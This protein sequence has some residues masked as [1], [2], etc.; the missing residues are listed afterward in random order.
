MGNPD[1]HKTQ[2][3]LNSI[4]FPQGTFKIKVYLKNQMH[5][6]EENESNFFIIDNT[7]PM[8]Q[9]FS[10][11]EGA[12]S[13]SFTSF[14]A[15]IVDPYLD[16]NSEGSGLNLDVAL[17][18]IWP[19]RLLTNQ[20]FNPNS[21]N[22]NT[23][24]FTITDG[25]AYARNHRGEI[26]T[27]G[28]ELEVWKVISG[29][30]QNDTVAVKVVENT[31]NGILKLQTVS[32]SNY[33]K[34]VDFVALFAIPSFT[35]NNG[36]DRVGAVP[37][38]P[39][40][41]DAQYVCRVLTLD[42]SGNK[43]AF[44]AP[45]SKLELAAGP[46]TLTTDRTFLFYGLVPPDLATFTSSS[47]T[48]RKGNIV[49]DAQAV[50]V[51]RSPESLTSFTLP[52]ANGLPGDGYQ[53][54]TGQNGATP[55]QGMFAF[56]V[57]VSGSSAG[58]LNTVCA[59]GLASGSSS[60]IPIVQLQAFSL[61]PDSFNP[62]ITPA[63]PN[64]ATSV[65]TSLLGYS[66]TP[67]PDGS[68][69][70]WTISAHSL[71]NPTGAMYT[72]T[73]YHTSY[74]IPTQLSDGNTSSYGQYF[75]NPSYGAPTPGSGFT[76]D[77]GA[78]NEK[79]WV[80]LDTRTS[81]SGLDLIFD[82]Q[83]SDNGVTWTTAF[84]NFALNGSTIR[85]ADWGYTGAHRY[86]RLYQTNTPTYYW[87]YVYE[88]SWY[89]NPA[90]PNVT[91]DLSPLPGIQS[92]AN[93]GYSTVNVTAE[94]KGSVTFQM[95]IGGRSATCVL[96]FLDRYPPDPTTIT[97]VSPVYSQGNVT[98]G[99]L[100]AVDHGGAGTQNYIIEQSKDGG[101]YSSVLTVSTI[102][103]SITGLTDGEYYFRVLAQDADGNIG[104][105]CVASYCLVDT[106]APPAADCSDVGPANLDPDEH[107]SVDPNITFY[108]S[109]TDNSSG[110]GEVNVQVATASD[111]S[112]LAHDVWIPAATSYQF[113]GGITGYDYY[114]RVRVKDRSGNIGPF[115]LGSNGIRVHY[116]GATTPPNAPII[117]TI[118]GQTA[119]P[120]T[121]VKTKKTTGLV[122]VGMSESSNLVEIWVDG[123][124]KQ[125]VIAAADGQYTHLIDLTQ[126]THTVK[127]RS[128]NGFAQSGFS[129]EF[130][131]IV[132]TTPPNLEL[133]IYM[134]G[135]WLVDRNWVSRTGNSHNI[136][137]INLVVSD[138][139]GAGF[140]INV[141]SIS[142][143]DIDDS[144]EY[145]PS[146]ASYP[147]P[148]VGN[149][150]P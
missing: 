143:Y 74:Y 83:Y 101:A 25:E 16:D 77:L 88:L 94:K 144:L 18:Q 81:Y 72:M 133:R 112:V 2:I 11:V 140:D 21:S 43:G 142:I 127:T 119:I 47:I 39:V 85:R 123:G 130:Q 120:G 145:L 98:L 129:N 134:T 87:G 17:P 55:G 31:G 147:N 64:G 8:A 1:W 13:N 104:S 5:V 54:Y 105:P 150:T 3:D 44:Y 126:G 20:L 91:P 73:G 58:T 102:S 29:Q 32:G 9:E 90:R 48:T 125:S 75:Y 71:S 49:Q 103:A 28:A 141:A 95:D 148:L 33:A 89:L 4:T 97:S 26:L 109:P 128:H 22:T 42:K 30:Y 67:V 27:V 69:A 59:I 115:G 138:S 113:T 12:V 82:I 62:E 68:L 65:T 6:V 15:K 40:T 63:N 107:F 137:Y 99:F 122:I 114:A 106:I 149:A 136:D 52:D 66:G 100:E 34:N 116:T 53:V 86:W 135:N 76:I 108:F 51:Q 61:V 24:S 46:I 131:I 57:Q 23:L 37:I 96:N 118:D 110:V 41:E 60:P 92:V 70:T 80:R 56:G 79:E 36:I 111:F 10:P 121:P 93:G 132:D 84:S 38:S 19:F 50:T 146:T 117:T 45:Y 35:S 14:N 139:G 7:A 78:G 124:Y